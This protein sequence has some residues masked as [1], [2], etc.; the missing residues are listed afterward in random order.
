M[1]YTKRYTKTANKKTETLTIRLDE[2]QKNDL[3]RW[4]FNEDKTIS[5]CVLEAIKKNRKEF[6]I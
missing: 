1:K 6:P 5:Q 4:A 2:H 3:T